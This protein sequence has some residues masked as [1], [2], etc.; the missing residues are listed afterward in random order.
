MGRDKRGF[1]Q[2]K[3]GDMAIS[4]LFWRNDWPSHP[5]KCRQVSMQSHEDIHLVCGCKK[6]G[7]VR[8]DC[9]CQVKFLLAVPLRDHTTQV[10]ISCV[11]MCV[12]KYASWPSGNFS[13]PRGLSRYGGNFIRHGNFS[14]YDWPKAVSLAAAQELRQSTK[15]VPVS[16]SNRL[17]PQPFGLPAK[18]VGREHS[19]QE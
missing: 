6:A 16:Q 13:R 5:K 4:D 15:I 11:A 14:R 19:P 8:E 9:L 7:R 12:E 2:Y 3:T 1:R 17:I 10:G 18:S